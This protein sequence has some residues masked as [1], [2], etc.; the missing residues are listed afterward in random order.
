M[1]LSRTIV[2]DSDNACSKDVRRFAL[3][4]NALVRGRL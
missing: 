3:V 2:Y 1:N 4:G